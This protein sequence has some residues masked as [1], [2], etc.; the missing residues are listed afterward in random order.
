MTEPAY[1]QQV[2]YEIETL[3]KEGKYE[4]ARVLLCRCLEQNPSDRENNLYLLLVNVKLNGPNSYEDDI[5]RLRDLLDL[6]DTEKE[7]VRRIFVL[8]FE[9]AEKDGRE[10]QAWVYQRLL[11][12]LLLAQ[13]LDQP[14]HKNSPRITPAVENPAPKLRDDMLVAVYQRY[15]AW[16]RDKVIALPGLI[17]AS[18]EQMRLTGQTWLLRARQASWKPKMSPRGALAIAAVTLIIIPIAYFASPRGNTPKEATSYTPPLSLSLPRPKLTSSVFP[19]D[20]VTVSEQWEN[21]KNS[22]R[23]RVDANLAGQLSDLRRAYGDWSQK[24]RN[25]MGS[26]LVKMQVDTNGNVIKAEKATSRLTDASFTEVVLDEARKWKFPKGSG[27]ATEFMVPLLFVPQG[28][29]PRTIIRWEKALTSSDVEAKAVSPIHITG[30]PAGEGEREPSKNSE[31]P[32]ADSRNP[33]MAL[34]SASKIHTAEE[35]AKQVMEVKTRRAAP[36]RREP[37]F[38][39]AT[40]EDIGPETY[41]SVLEAKGDWLKVKTGPSGKVGYLRKEYVAAVNAIR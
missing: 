12:R 2:S 5:D 31:Q 3:L 23:K 30:L 10:E 18:L 20:P 4:E 7:I 6:S 19:R 35:A 13:A 29:D 39:A 40:A 25:L 21:P 22:Y 15:L 11:R 24:D 1:F 8:G 9:A 37:R 33:K 38:A 28:M 36:L 41:I 34:A 26:L 17:A 27:E 14:I 16:L 32:P